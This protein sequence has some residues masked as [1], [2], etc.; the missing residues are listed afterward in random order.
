MQEITAD[1]LGVPVVSISFSELQTDRAYLDA[2]REAIG[3]HLDAFKAETVDE[4]LKKY[5]RSSI[6]VD[7]RDERRER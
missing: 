1:A 4:A 7:A 2:L 6:R 5:L 3:D